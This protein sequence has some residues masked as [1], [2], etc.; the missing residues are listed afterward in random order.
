VIHHTFQTNVDCV[1]VRK[2]NG[3]W[4]MEDHWSTGF[5]ITVTDISRGGTD[6]IKEWAADR[7]GGV[8]TVRFVRL[9]DTGDKNDLPYVV[10]G[11]AQLV[12]AFHATSDD[13]ILHTSAKL[14]SMTL[15]FGT[16]IEP[17]VI[18][19]L[20]VV[21]GIVMSV[22]FLCLLPAGVVIPRYVSKQKAWWFPA[23]WLIQ[24]TGL[25]L[26]FAGFGVGVGMNTNGHFSTTSRT[27]GFHSISGAIAM[28]M[29]VFQ[30]CLGIFTCTCGRFQQLATGHDL[31]PRVVPEQIHWWVG[32][33]SL[34]VGLVCVF[35]G[36]YEESVYGFVYVGVVLYLVGVCVLIVLSEMYSRA[37]QIRIAEKAANEPTEMFVVAGDGSAY[38]KM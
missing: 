13:Y 22:A 28:L 30:A 18:N 9:L 10:S 32:R 33:L 2:V 20:H 8:T 4:V 29:L 17:Y 1:V 36:L 38:V 21:H 16:T 23:H 6:D 11:P 19:S 25:V 15:K 34:L 3:A 37:S 35:L 12:L 7:V 31:I 14:V 5:V 26:V 27:L 24:T